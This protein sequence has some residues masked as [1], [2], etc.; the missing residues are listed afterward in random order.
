MSFSRFRLPDD[1]AG[2]AC[3]PLQHVVDRARDEIDYYHQQL[4]AFNAI[5]E[6]CDHIAAGIMVSRGKLL[7]SNNLALRPERIEPLLHHEVGTHLV[8][9]YNGRT[10]PFRQLYTGLAGYEEL[11]EGLAVLAEYLCGGLTVSRVR[12]LASRVMAVR[13]VIEGASF[14]DTFK[15]LND[16]FGVS[17]RLA[18]VTSLR[19]HR[20]GGLTKDILYLRGL[21]DLLKYLEA[22]HELEPLYVGKIGLPHVPYVQELRRRGII[23]PPA[24]LPRFWLDEQIRERLDSCRGRTILQLLEEER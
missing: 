11:Q 3:V 20:G 5:V 8:T 1:C 18:F 17:D 10:Q 23:N 21:R 2:D 7:I 24:L 22:G 4:P 19:V 9:Y 12:S 14:G 6:V 15:L 13:S 16:D